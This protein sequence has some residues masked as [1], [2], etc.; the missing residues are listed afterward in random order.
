MPRTYRFVIADVFT[1]VP[2][3]G[4]QLGVFTNATGLTDDEMQRLARELN[5]SETTFVLPPESDG[6][7]RMR[8][9]TPARELPFAGHPT[10]GTAFV[11]AG[12]LQKVLLRI[13]TA[14]GVVPVLLER[15]G[16]RIVFGSM[17]Q[18]VP[19]IEPVPNAAPLL[20]ALGMTRSE[21]PVER[22]DNGV[23]HLLVTLESAEQVAALK[24]NVQ[25]LAEA[26]G[27]AGVSCFAAEGTR[28]RTRMFAPELGVVEDP[29]TGSAAGPIAV[30]LARHGR[31]AWGEQIEISQGA[32]IGRPSTLFASAEVERDA[33]TRVQVGGSAVIVARGEFAL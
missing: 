3:A 22:Y 32:E 25:L 33:A 20:A 15:E 30:H 4:N 27:V 29:A 9:F 5:F 19:T 28:V 14:R 6:D 12:P 17:E 10:L 24:P 31:I 18:P 21:L 26:A 23:E 13:E 11:V 16:A 8:I 7:I 2:F 1:D